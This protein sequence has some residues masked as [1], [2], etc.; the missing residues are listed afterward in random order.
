MGPLAISGVLA[1]LGGGAGVYAWYQKNYGAGAGAGATAATTVGPEGGS[2]AAGTTI[3]FQQY[4]TLLSNPVTKIVANNYVTPPIAATPSPYINPGR[5]TVVGFT[6]PAPT[7]KAVVI[8][9]ATP[10]ISGL[11]GH[12][13]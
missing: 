12:V 9:S 2:A 6:Q 4:D 10:V 13:A 1:L 3:G 11:A 5:S 8:A 7:T